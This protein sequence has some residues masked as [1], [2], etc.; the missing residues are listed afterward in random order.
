MKP[1]YRGFCEHIAEWKRLGIPYGISDLIR[2]AAKY[3]TPIPEYI[4]KNWPIR[5]DFGKGEAK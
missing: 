2:L 5:I 3:N 1:D 4:I